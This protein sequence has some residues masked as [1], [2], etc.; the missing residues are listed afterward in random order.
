MCYPTTTLLTK[1]QIIN[2]HC[3]SIQFIDIK[4]SRLGTKLLSIDLYPD[5]DGVD[6][7]LKVDRV[8]IQYNGDKGTYGDKLF[9]VTASSPKG[10]E[11][12]Q[13]LSMSHVTLYSNK[14]K[15]EIANAMTSLARKMDSVL[16]YD[17]SEF[18]SIVESINNLRNVGVSQRTH[19]GFIVKGMDALSDFNNAWPDLVGPDLSPKPKRSPTMSLGM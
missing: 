13:A 8:D 19:G 5:F 7:D 12:E 16:D 1:N 17:S 3:T 9:A 18:K 6:D 2:A 15:S 4:L 11:I 10:R 14:I